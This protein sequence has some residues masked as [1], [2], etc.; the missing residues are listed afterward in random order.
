MSEEKS[1]PDL[2]QEM[3]YESDKC[4][5]L[6]LD[7]GTPEYN[8]QQGMIKNAARFRINEYEENKKGKD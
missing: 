1:W 3:L 2:I 5:M 4:A 7:I 8:L 6:N